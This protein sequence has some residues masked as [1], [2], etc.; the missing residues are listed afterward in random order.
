MS[1]RIYTA[2]DRTAQLGELA[3]A[4]K[5]L[6]PVAE[7]LHLS[8]ATDYVAAL[9]RANTL[10]ATAF[11]QADLSELARSIPDVVGRHKDWESQ[12]LV[13]RADGSTGFPDWLERLE[14]V[15]QPTL[16]AAQK[17]KELGYY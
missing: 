16:E 15:L 12:Y 13:R 8:Q 11:T 4:L 7:Q 10:M 17:L 14:V 6:V 2:G 3:E 1:I 5:Q 9:A